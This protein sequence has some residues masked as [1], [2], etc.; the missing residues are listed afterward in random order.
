MS[1]GRAAAAAASAMMT[2]SDPSLRRARAEARARAAR[3]AADA[4]ALRRL[5]AELRAD[6]AR[7]QAAL[8]RTQA[9]L[10]W[11]PRPLTRSVSRAGP[12]A[13]RL[14]F[15]ALRLS[16]RALGAVRSWLRSPPSVSDAVLWAMVPARHGC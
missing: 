3:A 5:A 10:D 2:A 7:L 16:A 15:T 8:R 4:A 14:P 11:W 13:G 9:Q 6:A 1:A 12:A